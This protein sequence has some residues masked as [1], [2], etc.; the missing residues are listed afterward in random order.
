ML[1]I[2]I[3]NFV[4]GVSLGLV[5]LPRSVA[6]STTPSHD[7]LA[8]AIP[9]SGA[10][11]YVEG[12]TVGSTIETNEP[13]TP[14]FV[15]GTVWYRWSP[16]TN[17]AYAFHTGSHPRMLA[18]VRVFVGPSMETLE[19]VYHYFGATQSPFA[20]PFEASVL[21]NYYLQISD[22]TGRAAAFSLAWDA[23]LA[24]HDYYDE[25]QFL[26]GAQ[27]SAAGSTEYATAE[28]GEPAS[29]TG[30]RSV[31]F[32]WIAPYSGAVTFDT[33]GS[34]VD[35]LLAAVAPE[36]Q[37]T[38]HPHL[39]EMAW[40]AFSDDLDA[41]ETA[42]EI[43]FV[44]D[45][46]S[47]YWIGVDVQDGSAGPFQLNYAFEPDGRL[48]DLTVDVALP[49][50]VTRSFDADHCAVDHGCI[51]PGERRLLRFDTRVRNQGEADLYLGGLT[52][53]I[54]EFHPCHDHDHLVGFADYRLLDAAGDLVVRGFKASFC[55]EDTARWDTNAPP[56]AQYDCA[57]IQAGWLD[58]YPSSLECQW[59]DITGVAPGLYVL[60]QEV[61][62]ARQLPE[63]D[64][65]NNTSRIA[66]SIPAEPG[67]VLNDYF[68]S[69]IFLSPQSGERRA[70]NHGTTAEES[71][72]LP[73]G[74]RSVWFQWMAPGEGPMTLD[75][76]D[77][78]VDTVLSVYTGDT[79]AGL[80]EVALN[81]DA[82]PGESWSRVTFTAQSNTLYHVR[83]D[84]ALGEEGTYEL[85]WWFGVPD[86]DDFGQA[87][88]LEDYLT[89]HRSSTMH[90]TREDGE[91]WH[92]GEPGGR[93]LWFPY[94][95]SDPRSVI[96]TT[97]LSDFDTLLA[98]YTGDSLGMLAEVASNDDRGAETWS[99][100][101]FRP[102]ADQLYWIA[103]DGKNGE[104]GSLVL[105]ISRTAAVIGD[106]A[107]ENGALH[108][109]LYSRNE[110]YTIETSTNLVDWEDWMEIDYGGGMHPLSYPLTNG[111]RQL[112][113]RAR[114]L[115]D[116]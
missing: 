110:L 41:G 87:G 6:A 27:G 45:A 89:L 39:S 62:I 56:L 33:R 97:A 3:P 30:G 50:I 2:L 93:S 14:T 96:V 73:K 49:V 90:A 98:V 74:G 31:W 107:R 54:Y 59:I 113:F 80:N 9:L 95:P 21:T 44:A 26:P 53:L 94:R 51:E 116:D 66:I 64:F 52:N 81:D 79:L 7:D 12:T 47:Q 20:G 69:Q 108:F 8:D 109:T 105:N 71:E 46:G 99:E 35:T 91:P 11:G 72:P 29:L 55:L 65:S 25:E 86:N 22:Y 60:E 28:W 75:T 17:G 104:A 114:E 101:S 48:P 111:V 4:L 78:T 19:E 43:N 15:E 77:S 88:L 24:A 58:S 10:R 84:S 85:S 36:P 82:A 57:G 103:V 42:S 40:V 92:A 76:R 68:G 106:V 112:F 23:G 83:A 63:S 38:S 61:N 102:V 34:A 5:A 16:P 115:P 100:V 37:T 18:Q 1:R 13:V 32:R 67:L 70:F